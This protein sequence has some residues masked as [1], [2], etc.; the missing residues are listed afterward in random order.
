MAINYVNTQRPNLSDFSAGTQAYLTKEAEDQFRRF[1]PE[2]MAPVQDFTTPS[3]KPI[4]RNAYAG[5]APRPMQYI[6]PSDAAIETG[7]QSIA[8]PQMSKLKR[9]LQRTTRLATY[10]DNPAR[11]KEL[12][13]G[14][15]EGV[16]TSLGEILAQSR[17]SALA[18]QQNAANIYNQN[19]TQQNQY[20]LGKYESYL[21]NFNQRES[22]RIANQQRNEDARVA[23]EQNRANTGYASEYSKFQEQQNQWK[24]SY[25]N[26]MNQFYAQYGGR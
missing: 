7:A 19:V 1:N 10:E 16:G 12:L 17:G 13:R 5:I 21:S 18:E 8:A 25:N 4:L 15:M 11:K 24:T 14:A 6:T 20:E 3:Y 22:E 9:A 2:P 26:A 23:A